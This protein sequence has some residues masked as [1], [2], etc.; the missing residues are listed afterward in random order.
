[1]DKNRSVV[2]VRHND[3]IDG[4]LCKVRHFTGIASFAKPH[5]CDVF[6][7]SVQQPRFEFWVVECVTLSICI[8]LLFSFFSLLTDH[9]MY[10]VSFFRVHIVGRIDQ[11]PCRLRI[12][13]SIVY[14]FDNGIFSLANMRISSRGF[15][16]AIGFWA[17]LKM[18][19][20]SHSLSCSHSHSHPIH[21]IQKNLTRWC[22]FSLNMQPHCKHAC[23]KPVNKVPFKMLK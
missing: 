21:C 7:A 8:L 3:A 18:F 9:R 16:F 19:S 12:I 20:L 11:I 23:S 17:S 15:C 10:I 22:L 5:C 14:A 2:I 4:V 6:G 1:M 13:V